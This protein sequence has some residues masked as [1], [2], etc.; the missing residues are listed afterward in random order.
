MNAPE[1]VTDW[2]AA[3]QQLLV[4]E[5]A[6]LSALLG[7]EARPGEAEAQ[8]TLARSL[9]PAPAAVDSLAKALGLTPEL[10]KGLFGTIRMRPTAP[11]KRRLILDLRG[12][13]ATK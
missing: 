10:A 2:T 11:D 5:F 9:M 6:R 13:T 8:T 1:R 7:D 4:A 12:V 3:N